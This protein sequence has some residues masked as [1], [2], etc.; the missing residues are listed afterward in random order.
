ML[1]VTT[2][3]FDSED[4]GA[5]SEDEVFTVDYVSQF[6]AGTHGP[7]ALVAPGRESGQSVPAKARP[8]ETVLYLN[9]GLIPAFTITRVGD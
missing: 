1:T 9:T 6:T 4:G 8:G 2:Y 5:L 7:P 3:S